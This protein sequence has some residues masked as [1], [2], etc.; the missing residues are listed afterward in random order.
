MGGGEPPTPA[1]VKGITDTGAR[2]VPNYHTTEIG[3]VGCGCGRPLDGNDLH[4]FKDRA[5]LIQ[6]DRRVPG[7]D[8]IVKTFYFTTLLASAPKLMLNV[9]NDD[10][11]VIE[12]RSCGCP[13]EAFGFTEHLRHIRSFRKL[14]G[15]GVTLV[16]SEMVRILEEVLPDRFGGSALDY[17]LMEEEDE[18]GFTRLTLLV[19]PKVRIAD[20]AAVIQAV[21]NAL[22][23][24]SVAANLARVFWSQA[25]TLQIKRMEPIWTARGKMMPI[26]VVRQPERSSS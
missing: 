24:S 22:E 21:L 5:A 15:E 13:L 20:E 9:E 26:Y 8:I 14:T 12:E 4:L 25:G 11:G 16:G 17:Q 3:H 7:S 1:K 19:S 10:Y 6:H 23:H 18:K 2:W